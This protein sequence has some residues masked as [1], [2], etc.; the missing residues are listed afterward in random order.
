MDEI[1]EFWETHPSRYSA[2]AAEKLSKSF[3]DNSS[4]PGTEED[5]SGRDVE[6]ARLEVHYLFPDLNDAERALLLFLAV[7]RRCLNYGIAVLRCHRTILTTES[8]KETEASVSETERI[9]SAL[10]QRLLTSGIMEKLTPFQQEVV[11]RKFL[12]IYFGEDP[13]PRG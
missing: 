13:A 5:E 9:F 8:L 11:K 12:N 10:R 7:E 6:Y 4:A 2:L 3:L 1:D